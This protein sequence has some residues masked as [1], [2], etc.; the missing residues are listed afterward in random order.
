MTEIKSR[1]DGSVIYTAKGAVDIR[2]AVEDARRNGANLCGADLYGANLRGADLRGADL[3]GADLYGAD[4][5]GANLCGANL[6]GAN[7]RGANLR[8]A[9]LYGANLYGANLYG[10]DLYGAN[11]RGANL[12]GANLYGANLRGADLYGANGLKPEF[13]DDLRILLDQVGKIRAYKLVTAD[14]ESPIRGKQ[15]TYEIGSTVEA[16]ASTDESEQCGPGVNIATLPWCL[17]NWRT[18]HRVLLVEFTAKD[19]AAIPHGTDGK[20]RVHKAKVIREI[21]VAAILGESA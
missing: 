7:L 4:L 11:L 8:G 9:D 21:D 19:I 6:Y 16:D 20:F 13:T 17:R 3:Y 5:Y 15:L 10:A 18:G 2:A 12:R 1:Y 14:L